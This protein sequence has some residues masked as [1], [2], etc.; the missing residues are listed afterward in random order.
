[1]LGELRPEGPRW[2]VSPVPVKLRVA[3]YDKIDFFSD[4]AV[5]VDVDGERVGALVPKHVLDKDESTVSGMARG[6]IDD[7]VI[8]VFPPTQD[9]NATLVVPEELLIQMPD[10]A[11]VGVG[12]A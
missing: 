5:E 7:R 1:M 9:G 3:E 10:S 2:F 8:V 11:G 12:S 4:V 6:M